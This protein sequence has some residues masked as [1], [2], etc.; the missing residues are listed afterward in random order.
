MEKAM[1]TLFFVCRKE[2][3]NVLA[4]K[5][6]TSNGKQLFTALRSPR[7]HVTDNIAGEYYQFN[8]IY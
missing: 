1:L 8:A 7:T 6:Y 4:S 2:S 3:M 5:V